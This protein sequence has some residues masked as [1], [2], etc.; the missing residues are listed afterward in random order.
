MRI[1]VLL[2]SCLLAV[3][4]GC[5]KS[6]S[7]TAPHLQV[8]IGETKRQPRERP[9]IRDDVPGSPPGATL[10]VHRRGVGEP[11]N[12]G[13][14]LAESSEGGFSV[15]LPTLFNDSTASFTTNA[16]KPAKSY[17]IT[18]QTV[19]GTEYAAGSITGGEGGPTAETVFEQTIAANEPYIKEKQYISHAGMNGLHLS[20][21]TPERATL[22]RVF[23]TGPKF[24]ML[25]ADHKP[26]PVMPER[27]ERD[28]MT[29]LNSL[30]VK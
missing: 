3:V 13:W 18:A 8:R 5:Q 7:T 16:G 24:Y 12:D 23:R 17:H 6:S 14:C 29:F 26:G 15:K 21:S 1:A 2:M 20:V 27:V 19:A 30:Q 28:A 25:Y 22:L 10:T 9:V 11:D 4:V